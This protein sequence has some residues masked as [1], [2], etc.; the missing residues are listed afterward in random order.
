MI[1]V[2]ALYKLRRACAAV[3]FASHVYHFTLYGCEGTQRRLPSRAFSLE[4][5]TDLH[6]WF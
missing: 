5:V 1:D 4:L 2:M 6:M 3:S